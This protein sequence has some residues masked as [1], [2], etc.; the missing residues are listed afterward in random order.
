M[1]LADASASALVL[2]SVGADLAA[3]VTRISEDATVS[4]WV[5]R[6]RIHAREIIAARAL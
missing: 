2:L 6:A 4:D 1:C 5:D 3:A